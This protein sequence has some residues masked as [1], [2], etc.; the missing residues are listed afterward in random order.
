MELLL[1]YSIGQKHFPGGS[2]GKESTCNAGDLGW[3][4]GLRRS[5][6]V[7]HGNTFQYSYLE[8]PWTEKPGR[9]QS[10]GLQRAGHDSAI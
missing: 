9:L 8:N 5:P 1:T 4:P 10:M 2:V 7:G 3:I 6:G